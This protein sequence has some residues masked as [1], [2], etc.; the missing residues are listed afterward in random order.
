MLA[1][2]TRPLSAGA[3][4][5]AGLDWRTAE[6]ALYCVRSVNRWVARLHCSTLSSVPDETALAYADTR[7]AQM[8]TICQ[9]H[10]RCRFAVQYWMLCHMGHHSATCVRSITPSAIALEHYAP[11]CQVSFPLPM[12]RRSMASLQEVVLMV[13]LLCKPAL[14]SSARM[15]Q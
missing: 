2:L 7:A 14:D 12:L 11:V 13:T 5:G 6:A 3:A 15:L 9:P 1:L 10:A 8:F 4:N